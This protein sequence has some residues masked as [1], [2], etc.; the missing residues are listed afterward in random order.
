MKQNDCPVQ[1]SGIIQYLLPVLY[2]DVN[3]SLS[4][5][6]MSALQTH[7]REALHTSIINVHTRLKMQAMSD[8]TL[9][10][11]RVG[12]V[13]CVN[14]CQS[15]AIQQA[16][17][18]VNIQYCYRYTHMWMTALIHNHTQMLW[19][20]KKGEE[21]W[22]L[23]K[24]INGSGYMLVNAAEGKCFWI[25]RWKI[26]GH[27]ASLLTDF[28]VKT[29]DFSLSEPWEAFSFVKILIQT[30]DWWLRWTNKH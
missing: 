11:I 24:Q 12:C 29:R 4:V 1:Y 6:M 16:C 2:W 21:P 28:L 8:L 9:R 23:E 25:C 22:P 10:S 13:R 17:L 27:I 3:S 15:P 5:L 20:A 18:C 14:W 7:R 26:H 30:F 19:K